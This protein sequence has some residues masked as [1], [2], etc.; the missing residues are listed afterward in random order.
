MGGDKKHENIYSELT[1]GK[2]KA[3]PTGKKF[4]WRDIGETLWG[5]GMIIGVI[6]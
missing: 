1:W 6:N 2:L 5:R 4:M 3:Q